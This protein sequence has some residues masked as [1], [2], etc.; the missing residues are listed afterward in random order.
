[1]SPWF[2]YILKSKEQ[3]KF[4][5]GKTD[6]LEKRLLEHNS[7]NNKGY[8]SRFQ[9]WV[10]VYSEIQPTEKVALRREKYFKSAAGR[11]WLKRNVG[12]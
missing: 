2:V 3:R 8:T 7:R 11:R 9:P 12:L 6:D 5:T 10:L 4:Y 1:M